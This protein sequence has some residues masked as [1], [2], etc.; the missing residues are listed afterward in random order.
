M[1]YHQIKLIA[2]VPHYEQQVTLDGET[3]TLAFDWN[4]REGAWYMNLS[5]VESVPVVMGKKVV[6]NW[7]FGHRSRS[8]SMPPGRF[9]MIEHSGSDVDPTLEDIG[10]RVTLVYADEDT[11]A[12]L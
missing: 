8:E 3:Y 11:I 7:T 5:D 10:D 9:L 6:S 4:E 2:D 12:E 1:S